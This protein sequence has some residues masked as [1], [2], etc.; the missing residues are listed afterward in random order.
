MRVG[1]PSRCDQHSG[2]QS[3]YQSIWH[4]HILAAHVAKQ[5]AMA[6]PLQS[7]SPGI[8]AQFP[9]SLFPKATDSKA[10]CR[11]V[12]TARLL[13]RPEARRG[14]SRWQA[15]CR[16]RDTGPGPTCGQCWFSSVAVPRAC[17]GLSIPMLLARLSR[18]ESEATS[19]W[20]TAMTPAPSSAWYQEVFAEGD[21]GL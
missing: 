4:F 6:E 13:P 2:A 8:W 7:A 14:R 21:E 11:L 20:F 16:A 10:P 5:K 18:S 12:V 15:W 19:G 9:E 1:E 3:R 17:N